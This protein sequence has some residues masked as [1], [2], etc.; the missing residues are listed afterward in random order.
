MKNWRNRKMKKAL[1]NQNGTVS[2]RY[3]FSQP[4]CQNSRKFGIS[5]TYCGSS[6]VAIVM[7]NRKFLPGKRNRAK[8]YPPSDD[9]TTVPIVATT[10]RKML[11]Q[12]QPAKSRTFQTSR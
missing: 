4:S 7:L 2:G 5:S 3:V 1:P 12:Y 8:A 10:V 9:E 11:F 6:I